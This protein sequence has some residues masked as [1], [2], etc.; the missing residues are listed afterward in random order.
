M[1]FNIL[2]VMFYQLNH[3]E[4]VFLGLKTW[5]SK[6]CAAHGTSLI[7]EFFTKYSDYRSCMWRTLQN[8][9]LTSGWSVQQKESLE[10]P[11]KSNIFQTVIFIVF[12]YNFCSIN[13]L[14]IQRVW[15]LVIFELWLT[16]FSLFHQNPAWHCKWSCSIL[17]YHFFYTQNQS[18]TISGL[19]AS[20]R[21]KPCFRILSKPWIK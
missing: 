20:Q 21:V 4:S 16:S 15:I 3:R 1:T 9:M 8:C 17:H 14:Y 7:T 10:S 12:Q 19:V 11:H 18:N 5:K 13:T 2:F 6:P